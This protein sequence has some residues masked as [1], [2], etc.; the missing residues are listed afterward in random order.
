MLDKK[1]V[2][3]MKEYKV[4]QNQHTKEIVTI[5]GFKA[6]VGNVDGLYS[7]GKYQ[8][9]NNLALFVDNETQTLYQVPLS[10]VEDQNRDL[11]AQAIRVKSKFKGGK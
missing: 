11:A 9:Q 2:I 7:Q 10:M 8:V 6:K 1:G 3:N 5:F 4:K